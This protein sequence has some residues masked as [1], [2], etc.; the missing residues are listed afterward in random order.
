[1]SDAFY[2]AFEDRYRGSREL[3]AS[4]L[5]AY[6]PFVGAL[7]SLDPPASALDLGCG[8]GEWLEL[9]VEEGIAAQGIDL[10]ESM[11][12]ACHERGLAARSA[13]ALATLRDLPAD[14]LALV[15]AFHL[16]E[17]LPFDEVRALIGQALRV[18]RPG[19]LLILE[20]PNPENLVVGASSF[21]LDP[22]HLRPIP[23]EL[24]SF[25]AEHAGFA[26]HAVVR[27]N[28]PEALDA[29]ARLGVMTVLNGVSPD[30][31]VVAQKAAPPAAMVA[32]DAAFAQAHGVR[33][34]A[35][36]TAYD[37]QVHARFSDLQ[38]QLGQTQAQ[39][40]QILQSYAWRLVAPID[41]RLKRLVLATRQGR[42]LSALKRRVPWLRAL[43]RRLIPM[44]LARRLLER[45]PRLKSWLRRLLGRQWLRVET[46]APRPMSRRARQVHERL[47]QAMRE[48][49]KH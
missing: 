49:G 20:T 2:R 14:S 33:L 48:E 29:S 3:I 44:R 41:R 24:L 10:D 37:R 32:L 16:V 35:L 27:L 38:S 22:S 34:G 28:E 23:S 46:H 11:L 26:R 25:A 43:A 13:E 1:M 31:S 18:L 36:A 6:L 30:Y 7:K 8:R 9:L 39:L 47:R 12:A 21:Y 45:A 19:G 17:H 15:S 40:D 5:R 4:R 42:L